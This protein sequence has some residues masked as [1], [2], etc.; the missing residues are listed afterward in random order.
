MI[1][2][3][4]HTGDFH[5]RLDAAR[6]ARLDPW[7]AQCDLYFDSGDL[8]ATGNLA[9]PLRPDP[10][11][12]LLARLRCD[13]SVPGNRDV[14]VLRGVLDAK[15]AGSSHPILCANLR[16]SDPDRPAPLPGSRI[17]EAG[18]GRVGVFGVMVPMVTERMAT[19]VASAYLWDSPVET[20]RRL[21]EELRPN[22]DCLIA[23][24]HI[25]VKQDI[26]LAETVPGLDL[27]LGGHSH[28][29]L[30][31][32]VRVGDAWICHTGSHGRFAGRYRWQSGRGVEGRLLPLDRPDGL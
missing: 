30:D 17:I 31:S 28:T 2:S 13:A 7:R 12:P 15:M 10:A 24:T 11:W 25:G 1:L 21:V 32:P 27:I 9:V 6:F 23:L 3:L 26:A 4:L 14:H 8:I 18:G 5:G 19:K 20:A 29:V 22:V 16:D